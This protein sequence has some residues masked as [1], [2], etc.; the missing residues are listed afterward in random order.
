MQTETNPALLEL[1]GASGTR[2]SFYVF[3]LNTQFKP[4]GGVYAVTRSSGGQTHQVIYVGQSGDLSERF[5]THHKA[6]CFRRHGSNHIC[7]MVERNEKT[8]LDI[9]ADLIAAYNPPCNG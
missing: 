4:S 5:D 8:R 6:D 1:I 7:A 9:E 3:D 2:Y